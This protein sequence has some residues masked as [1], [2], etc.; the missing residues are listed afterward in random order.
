M[1]SRLEQLKQIISNFNDLKA[2]SLNLSKSQEEAD[3]KIKA[4]ENI[5]KNGSFLA[6]TKISSS[7]AEVEEISISSEDEIE[8]EVEPLVLNKDQ[9]EEQ[10]L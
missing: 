4:L 8:D 7:S 2:A 1:Q 5:Q 9:V 6:D 3:F 10:K